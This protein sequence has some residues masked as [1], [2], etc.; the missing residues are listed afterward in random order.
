MESYM[1]LKEM[2]DKNPIEFEKSLSELGYSKS[3]ATISAET[4][5]KIKEIG[6]ACKEADKTH[7][8]HIGIANKAHKAFEAESATRHKAHV[9]AIKSCM[10][11]ALQKCKDM[12]GDDMSLPSDNDGDEKDS[13]DGDKSLDNVIEKL[14]DRLEVIEKKYKQEEAL[15]ETEK[16]RLEIKT[17]MGL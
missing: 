9:K 1:N 2:Q 15:S 14:I 6:D 5:A 13:A 7:K 4:K 8:E 12:T 17:N 11:K 10:N 3:G 16:I